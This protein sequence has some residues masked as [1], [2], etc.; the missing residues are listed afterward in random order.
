MSNKRIRPWPLVSIL[1]LALGIL[2]LA[3]LWL[4]GT[5]NISQAAPAATLFVNAATGNDGNDCLSAGAACA[6][7]GTA[8]S[9][10]IANDTIQIAAGT[11]NENDIVLDKDGLTLIGAG[12][13]ST[14]V[15]GGG[16]GRIFDISL[17]ST[18]SNL[19]IQNGQTPADTDIFVSGGGA[20][21]VGSGSNTLLQNVVI[22]N[23]V[24]AGSGGAIM[25]LG[26][27]T[28]DNSEIISNTANGVGGGLYNYS[29]GGITMTNSLINDNTAVGI[30]GG[31][32]YSPRPLNLTD[33]T[34]SG[35]SAASFG[36]GIYY[37]S[38]TAVLN[39]VTI[40]N[41]E[42]EAGSGFFAQ[43]GTITMTNSTVSGNV[44][45]NNNSGVYVSGASV[46]LTLIN[47]TIANNSRTGTNG[48]GWNGLT[49]ASSA[50]VTLLN[51]IIAD[52][53]ETQCQTNANWASS[54]NN[55]ASDFSC[56]LDSAGDQ[57]GVDPLLGVLADNG[58][59]TLT[60]A[61]QP[62]SPAIDAGTNSNCPATDQRGIARPYDGDNDGSATCDIGAYEAEHQLTI[63]DVSILE[64]TGGSVTAV[65]TVTLSPDSSQTVTVDYATSDGTAVSP[66]DYTTTSNS[67]TFNPGDTEQS[68]NVTISTDGDDESDE[69]FTVTLSNSANATILDETAVGTIIDDDGLPALTISDVTVSEGTGATNA[70][71]DVTL[72]PAA[73]NQV[74]VDY[75]TV[76]GTAVAGS[77]YTA[78]SDT[79]IFAIGETSKQI[80]V[81]ILS[82]S[83]DEGSSE[84]FT[85]QLS[86]EVNANLNDATGLGTITDNDTATL[87]HNIGPIV[88]EGNSG[89]VPATFTVTLSTPA[90]FI[91]TVDYAIS[92]GFGDTGAT[93]GEDY[94]G[95][96]S[97][98]LTFQPGDTS[99]TY[100]VDVVGDLLLE[101]DERITALISNA[102]VSIS[103]NGSSGQILNDDGYLLFLP[104]IIR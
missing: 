75:T 45:S 7:I 37:I 72:S 82:D 4:A 61:L 76:N 3:M 9:K 11:Y 49:G 92:D 20:V 78:Q 86:N 8:V 99:K 63:A 94:T 55:L 70:V 19:T 1:T 68:I 13:G 10:A 77:D 21:L 51:S 43:S 52:N 65:F 56:D 42:S 28:I 102:N 100:S 50:T 54:G 38:E 88:T 93:Y 34:V 29:F 81:P 57:E 23:N 36:G 44:A 53:Q 46:S 95:S 39:N 64:G 16:N 97:G 80:S 91:V 101:P 40:S 30:Q 18:I 98:T 58:G 73:A 24:A 2:T 85:V 60:H 27:L 5:A 15:D 96:I 59:A 89:T 35:N 103:V 47:S 26:N 17:S 32:I 74:T 31:G 41:N 25:N 62:G 104:T 84:D 67:L 79:L 12:V 22:S 66:G 33:V 90:A 6:T 14:I 48:T 71:F 87:S 69:T 83:Y